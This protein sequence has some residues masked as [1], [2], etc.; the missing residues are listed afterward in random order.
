MRDDCFAA[1][2]TTL[3]GLTTTSTPPP[4]ADLENKGVIAR[5]ACKFL[6]TQILIA[7]VSQTKELGFQVFKEPSGRQ[8]KQYP[9]SVA[10]RRQAPRLEIR[11]LAENVR[12][13]SVA[14]ETKVTKIS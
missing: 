9:L 8:R 7:K 10:P 14:N 12:E 13:K 2:R 5:F 6:Q 11:Q 1:A 3:K 4:F